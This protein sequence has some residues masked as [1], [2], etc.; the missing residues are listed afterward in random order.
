MVDQ[1]FGRSTR[2]VRSTGSTFSRYLFMRVYAYISVVKH[3]KI[4]FPFWWRVHINIFMEEYIVL[5][6]MQGSYKLYSFNLV[7]GNYTY[8]P[9]SSFLYANEILI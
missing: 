9:F 1:I 8:F 5:C 4:S 6:I 7:L 2:S 3:I